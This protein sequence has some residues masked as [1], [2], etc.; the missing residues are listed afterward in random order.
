VLLPLESAGHLTGSLDQTIDATT[1]LY[2]FLIDQ[3]GLGHQLIAA[4]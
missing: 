1:D 4:E 2:T 3:L